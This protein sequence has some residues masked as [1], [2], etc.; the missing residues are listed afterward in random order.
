MIEINE[1]ERRISENLKNINERI[2]EAAIKA[3]RTSETVKLIAVT[4]TVGCDEVRYA[5]NAGQRDFAEN[6]VQM[7]GDK[8]TG[9]SDID[10]SG[11]DLNWHLIGHL[12]TNKVKYCA[13]KVCLIHSLDRIS[14]AEEISRFAVKHKIDV[15]C[16]L[17]LNVSG[18]ESKS[19]LSPEE[20]NVF[21]E[22]FAALEHIY[23]DGLMTM[24]PF[25]AEEKILKKNFCTDT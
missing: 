19:G 13:D 18:E 20:I 8:L 4:K 9:L 3:G 22:Q 23:I 15:H 14:L 10:G 25:G 16:L 24:A 11:I 12:Q 2:A 21:L 5:I 7:L 17:Q 6:R 1:K